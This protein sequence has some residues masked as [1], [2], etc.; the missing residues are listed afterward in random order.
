MLFFV[1]K[2]LQHTDTSLIR[3]FIFAIQQVSIMQVFSTRLITTLE[4]FM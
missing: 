4:G 1:Q 3:N 2:G